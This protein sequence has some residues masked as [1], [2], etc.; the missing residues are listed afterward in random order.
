MATKTIKL[1]LRKTKIK[2]KF[3]QNHPKLENLPNKRLY[4]IE[5]RKA[6][7]QF[8]DKIERCIKRLPDTDVGNAIYTSLQT[9]LLK[10]NVYTEEEKLVYEHFLKL[11]HAA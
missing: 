11:L 6:R 8:H 9:I 10:G 2:S 5:D 3:D 7:S 1:V 4:T